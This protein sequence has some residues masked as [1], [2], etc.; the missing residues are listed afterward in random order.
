MPLVLTPREFSQI[1][2]EVDTVRME[3]VRQQSAD[4]VATTLIQRGSQQVH[5]GEF[6]NVSGSAARDETIVWQGDCSRMKLICGSSRRHA[7]AGS[8]SRTRMT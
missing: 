5:L 4:Q 3:T 7:R 6:F 2:I 1:P 8:R